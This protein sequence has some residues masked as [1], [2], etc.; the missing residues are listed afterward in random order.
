MGQWADPSGTA[1]LGQPMTKPEQA[2]KLY[3]LTKI[4][5]IS[6][7]AHGPR[8]RYKADKNRYYT[9]ILAKRPRSDTGCSTTKGWITVNYF[10]HTDHLKE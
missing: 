10:T 1:M 3:P 8:V 2:P 9:L 6:K 7:G 4:S 5:L